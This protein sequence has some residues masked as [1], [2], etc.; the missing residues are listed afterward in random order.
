MFDYFYIHI[1]KD[2]MKN[3]RWVRYAVETGE[4]R[5][6]IDIKR[7]FEPYTMMGSSSISL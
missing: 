4:R 3:G 6:L 1:M 7:K 2:I 5:T